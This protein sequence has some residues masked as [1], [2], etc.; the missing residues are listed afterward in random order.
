MATNHPITGYILREA[1]RI[2]TTSLLLSTDVQYR[3]NSQAHTDIRIQNTHGHH[4]LDTITSGGRQSPC[5]ASSSDSHPHVYQMPSLSRQEEFG[6][7]TI[8]RM[9]DATSRH[10]HCPVCGQQCR[11]L[12]NISRSN[13][14]HQ[15][16]ERQ[17]ING[18]GDVY[19][20]VTPAAAVQPPA[21]SL[22]ETGFVT[23]TEETHPGL[24]HSE[25]VCG[26]LTFRLSHFV[27]MNNNCMSCTHDN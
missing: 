27:V 24:E 23:P 19:P 25:L 10:T 17:F 3:P 2:P 4:T 8:A 14:R 16:S 1:L 13:Y 21:G 9:S 12:S 5:R 6:S 22:P 15:N 11:A 7:N 18:P 20:F 26:R